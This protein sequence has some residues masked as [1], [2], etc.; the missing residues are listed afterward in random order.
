V[1]VYGEEDMWKMRLFIP[2][3]DLFCLD[4]PTRIV[5][6]LKNNG[7]KTVSQLLKFRNQYEYGE[8]RI[9]FSQMKGLGERTADIILRVMRSSFYEYYKN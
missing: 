6:T 5:N 4:M 3:D 1:T 2:S 7:I 9:A 8:D